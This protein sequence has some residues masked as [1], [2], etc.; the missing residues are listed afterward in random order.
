MTPLRIARLEAWLERCPGCERLW[1]E[2]SDLRSLKMVAAAQARQAAWATLDEGERRELAAGVAEAVAPP[3]SELLEA[4][5]PGE[6][7]KAALGVPILTG[8]QGAQ[9]SVLTWASLALLA[10][11]FVGGLAAPG[12]LGFDA[13]GYRPDRDG[14][15]QAV[16]AT[17]AHDGWLHLGGNLL[18]AWLFGD[19][20][21]RRAP[22]AVV[23]AALFG[24][25]AA[26]LLIDGALGAGRETL[27]GA[28]GGVFALMGLCAVLQRR[29]RWLVPL[30][31][32]F[33]SAFFRL[34]GARAAVALRVP[35][36]VAMAAFVV[37][38]VA[39][40][41]GDGT[42]VAWVAHGVGFALGVL[43]GLALERRQAG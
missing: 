28:S 33:V 27:G 22:H 41:A 2:V 36:P 29:G 19:A 16:L 7:V 37:V 31:F 1:V 6:L 8:L 11:A 5:T 4:L 20:V 39:R 25:G 12:A 21:E 34:S 3:R 35:L 40:A 10:L 32:L 24:M 17:F 23:P 15:L 26:A 43:A 42:G 14:P 38:D 30:A 13:L 18:F 9:R